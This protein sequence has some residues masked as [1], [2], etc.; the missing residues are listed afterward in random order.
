[1]ILHEIDGSDPVLTMPCGR[2][3]SLRVGG[4]DVKANFVPKIDIVRLVPV[5]LLDGREPLFLEII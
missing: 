2:I 1:L 3:V 5:A 4:L